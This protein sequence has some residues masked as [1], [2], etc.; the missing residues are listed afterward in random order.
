MMNKTIFTPYNDEVFM[1][2]FDRIWKPLKCR[3]YA[4]VTEYS[5]FSTPFDFPLSLTRQYPMLVFQLPET[6][7]PCA[8]HC[9]TQDAVN[10]FFQYIC[11][12]EKRHD[13]IFLI[14]IL[15]TSMKWDI[16]VHTLQ[17]QKVLNTGVAFVFVRK[18]NV[19][20]TKMYL[21]RICFGRIV[22]LDS[23]IN[24]I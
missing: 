18:A 23:I 8:P 24:I 9:T 13:D 1:F 19:C 22:I 5:F 3:A 17:T 10:P 14:L 20:T 7:Y 4:R 6:I 15:I 2:Y 11:T 12:F 16:V 21:Y